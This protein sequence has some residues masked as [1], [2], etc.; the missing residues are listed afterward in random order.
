MTYGIGIGIGSGRRIFFPPFNNIAVSAAFL[1]IFF[2]PASTWL[3]LNRAAKTIDKMRNVDKTLKY[4]I[5][6]RDDFELL[7]LARYVN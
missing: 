4:F 2:L 3:G 6:S 5:L 1:R 7:Y